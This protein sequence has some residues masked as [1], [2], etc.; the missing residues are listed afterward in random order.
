[1]PFK[2]LREFLSYLEDNAELHRSRNRWGSGLG[3]DATRSVG[4]PFP[5]VV[6][7]P[8]VQNVSFEQ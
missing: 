2:D 4:E 5:E 1:M 6:E 8:G 3:I 7:V